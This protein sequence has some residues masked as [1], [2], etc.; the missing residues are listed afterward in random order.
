MVV[1]AIPRGGVVVGA[2][3]ASAIGAPLDLVITRKIGA[4]GDPELAIGAVTQDG[5]TILDDE[6]VTLLGVPSQYVRQ[7]AAAQ[8]REIKERESKYRG[9]RPSLDLSGKTVVIVDDG[10]ATGSTVRAAVESVKMGGA[11]ELIVAAPVGPP[12]VIAGLAKSVDRV[13]CLNAPEIFQATGQFYEEF[14]PVSDREVRMILEGFS[15]KRSET[16]D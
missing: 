14:P 15:L 4:P 6:L 16:R 2:K 9:G 7:E 3:V 10:I 5:R 11:K 1:L 12:S 13:F 8:L